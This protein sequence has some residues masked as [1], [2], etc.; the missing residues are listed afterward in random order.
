MSRIGKQII[1]IPS[2]VEVKIDNQSVE[3]KGPKGTLQGSLHPHVRAALDNGQLSVAVDDENE[4]LDRALWGLHRSLI[5]NMIVGVTQGFE[6]KLELNGVGYKVA[7]S[8]DTLN[9]VLGFSHEVKYKVPASITVKVEKNI[10]TIAGIDKQKVGQTAAEI[11]ALKKP[12]AYL[13]KGIKYAGEVLR[14]KPGKA[15]AKAA[16]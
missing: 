16:A 4:K 13:G 11:K 1:I 6:K 10:I 3:V 15:A 8:G 2:G 12:D 14:K 5:M 9:L 7:A